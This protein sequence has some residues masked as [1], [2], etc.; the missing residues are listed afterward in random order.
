[1]KKYRDH[2]AIVNACAS[3]PGDPTVFASGSDDGAIL[4]WDTRSKGPQ[5][6]IRTRLP[7]TSLTIGKNNTVFS[8]GINPDVHAWDPR[9]ATEPVMVVPG[10]MDTVTGLAISPDSTM[11]LVNSMDN[12]MRVLDVRP[13]C[14]GTRYVKQ[15]MGASHDFEK[16]LLRCAWSADGAMVTCGSANRFVHVWD[17]ESTRILYKL[18][19]H[20]GAVN[21]VAF[22]PTEPIV[23][24]VSNDQT[25]YIG[26]L[27]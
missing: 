27:N 26:E 5:A 1:M 19:G 13:F 11:L 24:S 15:F 2:S 25:V 8:A 12:A 20:T 7:I 17:Y 16:G 9:M 4:S 18:P 14:P 22:H 10:A 6:T 23:A 3:S 21:D